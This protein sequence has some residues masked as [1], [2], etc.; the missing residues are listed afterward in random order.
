M[1]NISEIDKN[2]KVKTSIE[3][4]DISFYDTKE[5]PFKIYGVFYENGKFRRMPRDVAKSINNN[6]VY[7]L[8]SNTAG[9]RVRFVTDSSYVAIHAEMPYVG[10]MP[11]FAFTGSIGF[12]LYIRE[13]GKER[14]FKTF[15][16]PVKIEDGFESVVEFGNSDLKEITIN[17]PLYSDVS[18]LYIG[19]ENTAVVKEHIPY[20]H[21]KPIVFYGSSI[22]QGGCASRP[23]SSYE[24]ILSRAFDADFVNL[25]FSGSARAED[26]M[27][28]YISKLP[29]SVF[30]YDYDHNAP[31]AEHLRKTHSKM[32][33]IIRKSNPDL[34]VI[35][36]SMPKFILTST[37]KE[38]FKIIEKTYLDA[39][40][41]G[42][43]NVYLISGEEL[44]SLVGCEGTVDNCHPTDAGFWSMAK[45]V[46]KV[47]GKI[48]E[49]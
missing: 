24:S 27:A 29:M 49:E 35:M 4:D 23:G 41:A 17:F 21:E 11:H 22:T 13:N 19:L 8:H 31:D 45:A 20:K 38:R 15:V 33:Q 14:Y 7:A 2:F 37:E 26:E 25:G 12:D 10:K 44:M 39:K 34:P 18:D 1:Q 16:P 28:E 6:G 42:D 43:E 40:N 48:L 3:K 30:V 9:G 36:M 47:L 32:F 5:S 46:G